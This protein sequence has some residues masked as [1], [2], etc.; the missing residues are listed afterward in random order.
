MRGG[1]YHRLFEGLKI[2]QNLNSKLFFVCPPIPHTITCWRHWDVCV[3]TSILWT[4][5]AYSPRLKWRYLSVNGKD[6]RASFKI[7]RA[8]RRVVFPSESLV[9]KTSEQTRSGAPRAIGIGEAIRRLGTKDTTTWLD[10][11]DSLYQ[12]STLY[13]VIAVS[14]DNL[15]LVARSNERAHAQSVG[16]GEGLHILHDNTP[17]SFQE[18]VV[19]DTIE[20]MRL[21][22]QVRA[23][24]IFAPREHSFLQTKNNRHSP[25]SSKR[26]TPWRTQ[27]T[28][29][30]IH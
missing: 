28:T 13:A 14:D 12:S 30:A 19:H 16:I 3:A 8:K 7:W 20:M 22:Y 2:F 23:L 25:S 9:L 26:P 11:W 21:I 5:F 27:Q 4:F 10:S 1:V 24:T 6:W 15:K 17:P 18:R 29:I